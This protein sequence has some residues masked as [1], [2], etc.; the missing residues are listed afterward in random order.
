MLIYPSTKV[1]SY[2]YEGTHKVTGQKYQGSRMRNIKL[3]RP[4]HIDLYI[5]RTS[6]PEIKAKF[7]EFD[8]I[9]VAEFFEPK[10]SW[11]HEQ[12][13]IWEQWQISKEQSLNKVCFHLKKAF[14]TIGK[15]HSEETI[16]KR[17]KSMIGK[18]KGKIHSEETKAKWSAAKLGKKQTIEHITKRSATQKGKIRGPRKPNTSDH[19]FKIATTMTKLYN[20]LTPMGFLIELIGTEELC[21]NFGLVYSSAN[22]NFRNNG[23]YKGFV[24]LLPQ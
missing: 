24:R 4:S 11:L 7:H 19:N 12:L 6:A 10:D 9:I 17:A 23:Y 20:F 3:N 22:R 1:L 5:Y 8:W 18:N 21:S 13:L 2:V 16:A 14:N 15:S